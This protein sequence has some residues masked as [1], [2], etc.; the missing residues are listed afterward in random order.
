M[1]KIRNAVAYTFRTE[2]HP[3]L[4]YNDLKG[5]YAYIIEVI[6]HTLKGL[7]SIYFG[8]VYFLH[9]PV[10]TSQ[11]AFTD[12]IASQLHGAHP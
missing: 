12:P 5:S 8:N 10:T 3:L 11:V 2:H 4:H 1:V 9:C 6:R 7:I